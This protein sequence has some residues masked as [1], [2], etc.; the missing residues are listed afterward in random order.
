MH[1]AVNLAFGLAGLAA[2]CST[3]QSQVV[4]QAF[5]LDLKAQHPIWAKLEGLWIGNYSFY[6]G[7]GTL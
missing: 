3:A 1:L 6:H 5:E 4:E 2:L 7:D